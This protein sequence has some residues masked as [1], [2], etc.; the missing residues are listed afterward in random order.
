MIENIS[1]YT[2]TIVCVLMMMIIIKMIIPDSTNKK[3]ILFVCGMITTTLLI[4]PILNLLNVD[5]N[6]VLAK[7]QIE[8]QENK[9][10]E[11]L[12]NTTIQNTYEK[13]LI[14]DIVNRLKENGYKV[15]NVKVEYDKET[16]KPQKV[17][18][19]L[20]NADGFIQPVKVEVSNNKK[21]STI[22]EVTKNK[23]KKIINDNYGIDTK[24]III[25]RGS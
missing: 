20:E 2:M 25:E 24:Y 21:D 13:N 16:Y 11:S 8:Y 6:E 18:L 7:N 4:E 12:Y 17:Y 15:S 19:N 3:Y 1:N 10:D 14:E 23:I 22:N 5:I 9:I